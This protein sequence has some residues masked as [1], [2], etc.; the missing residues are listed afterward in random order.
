MDYGHITGGAIDIGPGPL[1]R[2][3]QDGDILHTGLAV[4]PAD[5]L[6][7]KNWRPVVG[8]PPAVDPITQVLSAP[9]FTVAPTEIAV[10]WTVIALNAATIEVNQD[11]QTASEIAARLSGR[12]EFAITTLKE[13]IK[14]MYQKHRVDDPTWDLSAEAKRKAQKL[15]DATTP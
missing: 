13:V 14:E 6:L 7:A 10:S 5:E 15:I 2:Q 4:W 9:T 12:T 8:T 3:W 1:P 11:N